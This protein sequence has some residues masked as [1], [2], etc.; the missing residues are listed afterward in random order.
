MY[1]ISIYSF[2]NTTP[3]VATNNSQV[4]S[5]GN[6]PS[7]PKLSPHRGLPLLGRRW[8]AIGLRTATRKILENTQHHPA[9]IMWC[10]G[11]A[12]FFL[13][14]FIG[15][16]G[17]WTMNGLIVL[18]YNWY[19]HQKKADFTIQDWKKTHC[20]K[21]IQ[22]IQRHYLS[23]TADESTGVLFL[24]AHEK[25]WTTGSGLVSSIAGRFHGK[26]PH[27]Y[28][29]VHPTNRLGGLVHLSYLR[30]HCPHKNPIKITRVN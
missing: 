19:F 4:I 30:G 29:L 21:W 5:S 3:V 20:Q 27:S 16:G 10:T 12:G 11:E 22:L 26:S 9:D 8:L 15:N 2:T 13:W 24:D 25:T 14:I 7:F 28:L 6:P 1:N 18:T 23:S 17:Q